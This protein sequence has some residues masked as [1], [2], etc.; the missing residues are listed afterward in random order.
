MFT[1]SGVGIA[2][3]TMNY[4]TKFTDQAI[5]NRY[6]WCAIRNEHHLLLHR[7]SADGL[8]QYAEGFDYVPCW[9][10]AEVQI[11]K[12]F[13]EE[14]NERISWCCML[15]LKK[16]KKDFTFTSAVN[17]TSTHHRSVALDSEL[18]LYLVAAFVFMH[19][20]VTFM[21]NWAIIDSSHIF[22]AHTQWVD[23][24][25]SCNENRLEEIDHGAWSF[26]NEKQSLNYASMQASKQASKGI[27]IWKGKWMN[28]SF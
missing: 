5:N 27:I 18:N 28:L 26:S 13:K 8:P 1:R 23:L 2:F 10:C 17:V 12:G 16:K 11:E 9:G 19:I 22:T 15:M 21:C 20:S 25:G 6:R 24:K 7:A 3:H 4:A 14:I